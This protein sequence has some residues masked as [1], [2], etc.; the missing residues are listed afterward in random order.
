M[1]NLAN[2][3]IEDFS[4]NKSKVLLDTALILSS[5]YNPIDLFYKLLGEEDFIDVYKCV[6]EQ[7]RIP[8]IVIMHI[9]FLDSEYEDKIPRDTSF[10]FKAN[11]NDYSTF[12][13]RLQ[14]QE[15]NFTGTARWAAPKRWPF[16]P[17]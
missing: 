3:I 11:I 15:G 7:G 14:W 5:K 8:T 2:I 16:C 1:L 10:L 13:C 17:R 12:L 6:V 4:I 9:K